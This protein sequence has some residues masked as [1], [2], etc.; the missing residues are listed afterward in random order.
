MKLE[1]VARAHELTERRAELIRKRDAGV[2]ILTID[3]VRQD[4]ELIDLARSV[5]I[6]VINLRI[7][8]VNLELARLGV[9]A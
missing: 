2:F 7:R 8:A 1:D 9:T 5:A 3:G 6:G 4:Q